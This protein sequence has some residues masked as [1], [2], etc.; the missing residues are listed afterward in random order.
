MPPRTN[1]KITTSA[2]ADAYR[3]TA[4]AKTIEFSGYREDV[5]EDGS[6]NTL[7]GGLI[8]FRIQ[9]AASGQVPEDTLT[10][11]VKRTDPNVRVV[12]LPGDAVRPAAPVSLEDIEAIL[13]LVD[14]P[15]GIVQRMTNV[16]GALLVL[17]RSLKRGIRKV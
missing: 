5:D 10:V 13:A 3:S 11:T 15:E 8:E 6:Y 17:Q 7:M 4:D 16:R 2:V 12:H 14:S 9:R 1:I